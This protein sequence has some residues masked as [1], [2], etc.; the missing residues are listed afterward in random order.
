[1]KLF[2][3]QGGDVSTNLY[4]RT[5]EDNKNKIVMSVL[6]PTA[7]ISISFATSSATP[8]PVLTRSIRSLSL[9]VYFYPDE[10]FKFAGLNSSQK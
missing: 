2:N 1:M 3:M 5:K 4:I 10:V 9:L 6:I 7:S 8:H